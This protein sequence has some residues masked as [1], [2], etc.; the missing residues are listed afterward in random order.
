MRDISLTWEVNLNRSSS[1]LH[2]HTKWAEYISPIPLWPSCL[3]FLDGMRTQV[4]QLEALFKLYVGPRLLSS[5]SY[6]GTNEV[7][8]RT[9][10]VG[11][12][13]DSQLRNISDQSE[14]LTSARIQK[15]YPGSLTGT[16]QCRLLNLLLVWRV[17]VFS[18]TLVQHRDLTSY[19]PPF[20]WIWTWIINLVLYWFK[21]Q[22]L[23]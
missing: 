8:Y 14:L 19:V 18:V 20:Q 11:S 15:Y 6:Q 4:T 17:G 16:S 22:T 10:W 13:F 5:S 9:T 12:L 3:V 21:K 2:K 1:M 23:D 7:R